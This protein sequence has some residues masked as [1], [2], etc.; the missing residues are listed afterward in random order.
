[1]KN[2]LLDENEAADFC[3]LE[4][5]YFRNLQRT[6]HG[7]RFVRPSPHVTLYLKSDLEA[8]RDSWLKA[9]AA[10]LEGKQG[11]TR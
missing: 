3:G 9:N 8:W 2:E 1:M 7:P 11:G 10:D 5:G 4:T 6:A